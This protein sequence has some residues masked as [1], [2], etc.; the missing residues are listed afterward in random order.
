MERAELQSMLDLRAEYYNIL[1]HLYFLGPQPR[2]LRVVV[3]LIHNIDLDNADSDISAGAKQLQLLDSYTFEEAS[4]EM[5]KLQLEFTRVFFGPGTPPAPLYESHYRTPESLL[6]QETTIAKRRYYLDAGL[7]SGGKN[8][9]PE[10]HLAVEMEYLYYLACEAKRHWAAGDDEAAMD[11][12]QESRNFLQQ[13]S[14]WIHQMVEQATEH[15]G[16]PEISG[17]AL[18]TRGLLQDDLQFLTAWCDA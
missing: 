17:M 18:L 8:Q 3:N 11:S 13:C 12:L 9:I 1:R 10:D 7:I 15:A 16:M 14:G 6:M 2:I 4:S 5:E